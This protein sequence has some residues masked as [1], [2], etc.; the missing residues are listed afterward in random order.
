M[1]EWSGCW[2]TGEVLSRPPTKTVWKGQQKVLWLEARKEMR[3]GNDWLNIRDL[4]ADGGCSQA[5]LDFLAT[6]QM[7]RSVPDPAEKDDQSVASE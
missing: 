5:I 6:T 4:F 7:G 3:R 2:S 1:R